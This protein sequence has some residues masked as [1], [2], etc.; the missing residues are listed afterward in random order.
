MKIC[1]V[2]AGDEIWTKLRHIRD[3]RQRASKKIKLSKKSGS[4]TRDVYRPSIWF[5]DLCGFLEQDS[6]NIQTTDNLQ[7]LPVKINFYENV[8]IKIMQYTYRFLQ[9]K[10][11]QDVDN[12]YTI[13]KYLSFT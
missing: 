10:H 11:M 7:P 4:G 5:Y 8:L 1:D 9:C 12:S 3:E 2:I 13:V 6:D